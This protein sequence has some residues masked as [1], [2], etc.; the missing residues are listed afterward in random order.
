MYAFLHPALT[1]TR[2]YSRSNYIYCTHFLIHDTPVHTWNK[3]SLDVKH[4][5]ET[6]RQ[7]E[8]E[9]ERERERQTDRQTDSDRERERERERNAHTDTHTHIQRHRLIQEGGGGDHTRFWQQTVRQFSLKSLPTL[10]SLKP[11]AMEISF[12]WQPI[13]VWSAAGKKKNTA[14]ENWQCFQV[15]FSWT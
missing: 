10:L 5:R 14:K 9:R 11:S 4:E 6:D 2:D 3:W 13:W 1:Q 8:R 12:W 7:R 15:C